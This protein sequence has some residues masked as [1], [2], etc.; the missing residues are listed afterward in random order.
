MARFE[1]LRSDLVDVVIDLG[2]GVPAVIHWGPPLGDVDTDL[3]WLGIGSDVAVPGLLDQTHRVPVVP[4]HAEGFPGRPGLQGHRRGGRHWAPRFSTGF[5]ADET[6]RSEESDRT[7]LICRARDPIAALVLESRFELF[8]DGVLRIAVSLDNVGDS[9][10]M[11]D[12][13]SVSLP[14]PEHAGELGI[15]GGRWVREF[16]LERF[17]WMHGAWTSENRSGRTSHE[18]PPFVWAFEKG[19][20]FEHGQVWGIHLAWSGNHTLFAERLSDGRRYVQMGELF[21]PGEVC[22]DPGGRITTPEV[23][24]VHSA[25]GLNGASQSFHRYVRRISPHRDKPRPVHLNTW[26]AVYF[27]HDLERLKSL[28]DLAAKVGVERFVLDDGWFGDRRDDTRGLG[29]W[30]VSSERYPHGL[31]PLIDHVRGSGMEFGIWVEP[32]MANPDSDLLRNHPDWVLASD[33][34][35]PVLGRHQVV[36]DVARPEVFDHLLR[37]L[38]ELLSNNAISYVKWDMNRPLVQASGADGKASSRHQAKAV[39]QLIDELRSRHPRVEFESCASGGGRI[40]YEMLKRVERVWTSDS[41]D[42]LERQ[43]I[44]SGASTVLPL[45]VLGSHIGPSPAHT[46]RRR[47]SMA[48]R[49]ATALFGHLGIEADLAILGDQDLADVARIIEVYRQFRSLLHSGA[50][51]QFD[52]TDGSNSAAPGA[53]R[54][55]GVISQDRREALLSIVQMATE[56]PLAP[57]NLRVPGLL[58]R[59]RYR[60][61]FVPLTKDQSSGNR[62][63]PASAQPDWIADSVSGRPWS[64]SGQNLAVLGM[65]RPVLWPESAIVVHL[66]CA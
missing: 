18:H 56:S 38:D 22:I 15:F 2:H 21:H 40:D 41:N 11:L 43:D 13:L 42:A 35:L 20:S 57:G 51:V 4:V 25:I 66:S 27:D 14:L 49:G 44:M 6:S 24:A 60:V 39:Y 50:F 19:A 7:T 52:L 55:H 59:E 54:A 45:E 61:E 31:Q 23:V 46:T 58:D 64:M 37:R 53:S 5:S 65:R 30:V 29:D 36:L 47:H 9:P 62:L 3:D 34:Y 17:P 26:E 48:F 32:E 10:Y 63:G 33:G 8:S 28:A 1:I 12:S 16:H